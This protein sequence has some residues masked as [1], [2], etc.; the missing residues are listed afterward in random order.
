[1]SVFTAMIHREGDFYVA[2]CPETGTV[3]Q[4]LTLEEAL[5]N[6]REAT[7]L[8]LE[9]VIILHC[10]VKLLWDNEAAVWVAKSDDL[11][12]LALESG[13][14]DALIE[15]VKYIVPELLEMN[16][17][18]ADFCDINFVSDRLDRVLISG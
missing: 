1:M 6:L 9:E 3:S 4:G 18:K 10:K 2:E 13:S 11:P 12:N 15:R 14:C 16:D 5:N 8:Y 17:I 7:E